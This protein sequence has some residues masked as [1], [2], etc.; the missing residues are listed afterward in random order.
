VGGRLHW[1]IFKLHEHIKE[2]L[3][4]CAGKENSP[5]LSLGIDTWGLDFGLLD[6]D[7]GILSLPH[8]YR[9]SRF[10]N[11]SESFFAKIPKERVY[12]LTGIQFLPFNT[13]FQLE[14]MVRDRSPL[15][16]AATDLLFMPDLLTYLLTGV[17]KS[18]FTFATTSQLY[19]AR[20]HG[21]EDELFEALG[22]PR[23]LMQEVVM[24]GTPIGNLTPEGADEVGVRPI[25]VVA[26][27][28]HD[29][30]SAVAA[31]PAEGDD[32]AY[33]SSGTW[34]LMGI[35]TKA[36]IIT[37]KSFE[38]DFTNEGGVEGTIRFLK[39]ITGLWLL[40]ECRRVWAAERNYQYE[41]LMSLAEAA[42]P[43]GSLVD[44]D[45]TDFLNPTSMPDAICAVC[46][47]TRQKS[48]EAIGEFV[49][50]ILES[51]ALKYRCVLDMLRQSSPHPIN[52]L[53]VIG[54]GAHNR[55]LCQFTANATGLPV[56]AGPAE[57][58]AIGNIM[59]QA[60]S[61]GHVANLSEMRAVV[62]NS[63]EL[64]DYAPQDV[65]HWNSAYE[66]FR[67]ICDS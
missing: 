36:P 7:G 47:D 27:A 11:A 5:P 9:D 31:V 67:D 53:H 2:G 17:K 12:E 13:L 10:Q 39:N 63:F 33:I 19:S 61:S 60:M 32:W 40:E 18:E 24:P 55:M 38:N 41:E 52:R 35:E 20:K 49:R 25:P 57:A 64:V 26:V 34:S 14:S 21:W 28:T 4:Y 37:E 59:V 16:D 51:L 1:D 42:P 66:R 45:H 29:T 23:L 15:L 8:G 54:G 22:L 6:E 48:P 62:R 50:C 30:G 3:R 43:F 58:T 46:K 65:S 44:P 56:I